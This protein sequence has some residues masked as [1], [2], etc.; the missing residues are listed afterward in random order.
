MIKNLKSKIKQ[1]NEI[2]YLKF[3]GK[4]KGLLI[5]LLIFAFALC[6]RAYQ[7]GIKNPFGYDQVDNAW[8]AKNLIVNHR[9]PLTGMVA[10]ADSGIYIGPGYYYLVAF[11]Y[12][13]FG[14]NA[15]ASFAIAFATAI[16]TFWTVYY[17]TYKML[18]KEVAFI[19]TIINAFNFKSIVFDGV[20]WPVQLLP[21]VSLIIFYLLY[22]VISGDVRKLIPLAFAIGVAFNLHFTAIFFPIIVILTLPLFPRTK[23]TVKYI[24]FAL[25]FFLIWMVPSIIYFLTD[26]FA[27]SAAGGYL[28]TYYQG[29][30]LRRML[31]IMGDAL[32]QFDPYLVLD[33][34]APLKYLLLPLFFAVY[35]LK[36][37]KPLRARFLYLIAIW[38]LVPWMVFTTYSGE[39]SDYYFII[40][41]FVV[42]ML[43]VYLI[44]LFWELRFRLAK[45]TVVLFLLIYSVYGVM[46]FLPGKDVNNLTGEEARVKA[47]V[48]QGRKIGYQLGVPDSYLYWYAMWKKGKN[49]Y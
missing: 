43:L 35:Y 20:Q 32:I 37:T 36:N 41:R 34:L 12:W 27:N 3:I 23:E 22:K 4:N 5:V 10:K 7:P 24:L 14:L 33:K 21:A 1:I 40:S 8:A 9:F 19:A 16:F 42:L 13:I 11:F 45:I 17:V 49:V 30:H 15:Q 47:A 44:Y 6:L 46:Q 25:P 26:R 28:T 31:Q 48:S 2:G 39:I 18:G 29:F 38:I